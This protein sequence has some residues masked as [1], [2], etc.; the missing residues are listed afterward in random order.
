[1]TRK[2]SAESTVREIRRK[3]RKKY[4]ARRKDPYRFRIFEVKT[5]LPSCAAAKGLTPASIYTWS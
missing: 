2:N 1:M 3:T 4:S 5:V